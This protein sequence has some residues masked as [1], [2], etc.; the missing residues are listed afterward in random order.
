MLAMALA[1][2]W[3][4]LSHKLRGSGSAIAVKKFWSCLPHR[5]MW[6]LLVRVQ[7]PLQERHRFSAELKSTKRL[8]NLVLFLQAFPH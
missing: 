4:S 3:H 6:G 1:K 7:I 2:H 5:I 8:R